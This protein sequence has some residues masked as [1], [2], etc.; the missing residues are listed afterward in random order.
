MPALA[1]VFALLMAVMLSSAPPEVP[2]SKRRHHRENEFSPEP[3]VPTAVTK[4]PV[5]SMRGE[6]ETDYKRLRR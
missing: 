1:G 3:H 5:F 4:P 6:G 2:S